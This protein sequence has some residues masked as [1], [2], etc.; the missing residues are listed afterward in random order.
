VDMAITSKGAAVELMKQFFGGYFH[1]DWVDEDASWERV[2]VRY[3]V[4]AT[5]AEASLVADGIVGLIKRH[6]DDDAL[7]VELNELGCYYWPGSADQYRVWLANVA[8]A[9]RRT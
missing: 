9:L 8:D 2:A 6:P 7:V 4:E 3:R 5:D 1:Q